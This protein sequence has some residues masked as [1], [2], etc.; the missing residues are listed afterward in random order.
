MGSRAVDVLQHDFLSLKQEVEMSDD[1]TIT[2]L[3]AFEDVLPDW[4]LGI[5]RLLLELLVSVIALLATAILSVALLA[6]FFLDTYTGVLTLRAQ[7]FMGVLISQSG[8]YFEPGSFLY[9]VTDNL[10]LLLSLITTGLT[11]A[12]WV[13]ISKILGVWY[14]KHV[15]GRSTDPIPMHVAFQAFVG[16]LLQAVD[17]FFMDMPSV[18]IIRGQHEAYLMWPQTYG[19][20]GITAM[21][22]I[23]TL[24][25]D[26]LLNIIVRA[27]VNSGLLP[28]ARRK[29]TSG[30]A[31]TAHTSH[32][33]RSKPATRTFRRPDAVAAKA[34][35]PAADLFGRRTDKPTGKRPQK[36][37]SHSGV[38]RREWLEDFYKKRRVPD[39]GFGE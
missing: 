6:T 15:L 35:Y 19:D 7:N 3:E 2:F 38:S 11:A 21:V 24:L 29:R 27:L 13:N 37:P 34:D 39:D 32:K 9:L 20:W 18:P 10:P 12:M 28:G 4:V 14:N 1:K 31:A 17:F 26:P 36:P 8:V 30:F 23:L 16:L 22:G 25:N 33:T 5:I